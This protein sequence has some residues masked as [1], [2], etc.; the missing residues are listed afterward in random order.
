MSLLRYFFL[1]LLTIVFN[2]I[3]LAQTEEELFDMFDKAD[4]QLKSADH[5]KAAKGYI[6]IIEKAQNGELSSFFTCRAYL[7]IANIYRNIGDYQTSKFYAKKAVD[8]AVL[9]NF[10]VGIAF[11]NSALGNDYCTLAL[12]D[13]VNSDVLIDSANYYLKK[14]EEYSKQQIEKDTI[15]KIGLYRVEIWRYQY[16]L[17]AVY[18]SYARIEGGINK[19]YGKAIY[20]GRKS[21]ELKEVAGYPRYIPNSTGLLSKNYRALFKKLGAN[22]YSLLDSAEYYAKR[23]V[24]LS[25]S[26]DM[27]EDK[28]D[29]RRELARVFAAKGDYQAAYQYEKESYTRMDT[30]NATIR[31]AVLKAQSDFETDLIRERLNQ[32]IIIGSGVILVILVVLFAINQKRRKVEAELAKRISDLINQQEIA[33]LQGVLDGQEK[34][35]KRVAIDLHDRLGGLLSMVKLHFSS[36]E[37]NLEA[38]KPVKEKFLSASELLDLAANEVRMISHDLLSG[39]L[40]KFGLLP[41]LE[42]LS[43]KI[44]QTGEIQMNLFTDNLN[45]SLDGE[46][47]LQIYRIIQELVGNTL[48]H[49]KAS[50]IIIQL[51][52]YE[53]KVNLLVEDDGKGFDPLNLRKEAGIGMENLKARVAKLNGSLHIDSGKGAGTTISIDI[54]ITDD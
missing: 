34:E 20:F 24:F 50:E 40:A 42:D 48:K 12:R 31:E 14:A 18:H 17:S 5:E 52:E 3:S 28:I 8:E 51:N 33:S 41:A 22:D 16:A 19:D 21:V 54:P 37:E 11:S 35:R 46:Q 1:G 49:A 38:T 30:L 2:S 27:A 43:E 9:G 7:D 53:N 13:S 15:Y 10:E 39:V 36:V 45:G 6:Q 25:D 47:E 4:L 44:N 32:S 23:G 26:L 29:S